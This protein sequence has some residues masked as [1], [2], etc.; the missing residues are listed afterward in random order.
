MDNWVNEGKTVQITAGAILVP[1]EVVVTDSI[2]GIVQEG[3]ASGAEAVLAIEG[4]FRLAKNTSTAIAVGELVDFDTSVPEVSTGITP[5]A[6]DVEDFGIAMET[7]GSAGAFINVKLIPGGG[8][9]A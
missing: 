9:F 6:G 4:V 5:A 2:L 7:V 1:G 3:V 8:T